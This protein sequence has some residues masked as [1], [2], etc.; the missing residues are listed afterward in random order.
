M[1]VIRTYSFDSD[2]PLRTLLQMFINFWSADGDYIERN[3]CI[4][5]LADLMAHDENPT[6]FIATFQTSEQISEDSWKVVNPSLKVD[7]NTKVS[8]IHKFYKS[9][10]TV[11]KMQVQLIELHKL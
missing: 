9:K 8:E 2:L 4:N 6:E 3:A 11:D 5:L 7:S 10:G 1:S